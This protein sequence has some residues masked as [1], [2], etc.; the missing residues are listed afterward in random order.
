MDKI[1]LFQ[2]T[3]QVSCSRKPIKCFFLVQGDLVLSAT[4][5]KQSGVFKLSWVLP[6]SN[7]DQEGRNDGNQEKKTMMST[8]TGPFLLSDVHGFLLIFSDE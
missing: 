5:L 1:V 2:E 8:N 3:H 7:L 4:L 6:S